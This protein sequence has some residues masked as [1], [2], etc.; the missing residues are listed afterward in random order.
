MPPTQR[1]LSTQFLRNMYNFRMPIKWS[2]NSMFD[3]VFQATP[4]QKSNVSTI[5]GR[6]EWVVI[7]MLNELP[8]RL[9]SQTRRPVTNKQ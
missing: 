5:A 7:G 6:M 9:L 2:K 8:T 3:V 1:Q 4:V